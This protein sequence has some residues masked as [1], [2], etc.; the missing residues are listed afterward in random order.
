M[1]TKLSKDDPG[2][3]LESQSQAVEWMEELVAG[4]EL[5]RVQCDVTYPDN[6]ITMQEQRKAYRVFLIRHGAALGTV[7][8]L[9][10]CRK[11]TDNA[12]KRLRQRVV[13]TLVP[14]T[15]GTQ[16]G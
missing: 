3:Y 2:V 4:V 10:R 15:V 5:A 16:N 7:M 8:A 11:L 12:Y 1:S 14:T 6:K 13:N 9:Y